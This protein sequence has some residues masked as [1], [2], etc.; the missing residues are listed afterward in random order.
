MVSKEELGGRIRA[1]R[2]ERGLKQWELASDVGASQGQI[3]AYEQGF[4]YPWLD[5]LFRIAAAL[6][7]T[8]SELCREEA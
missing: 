2:I 1:R 6:E 4:H 3:S 5:V 7:T 8:V